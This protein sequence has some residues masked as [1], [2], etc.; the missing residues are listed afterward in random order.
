MHHLDFLML[1]ELDGADPAQ[2]L[3]RG[4]VVESDADSSQ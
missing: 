3:V 4:I 1:D 2:L